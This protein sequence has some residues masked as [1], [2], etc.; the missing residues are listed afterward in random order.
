MTFP[1]TTC[2]PEMFYMSCSIKFLEIE[3]TIEMRAFLQRDKKLATIGRWAFVCHAQ[4]TTE[5]A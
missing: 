2:L 3:S 4:E 5:P 1:N